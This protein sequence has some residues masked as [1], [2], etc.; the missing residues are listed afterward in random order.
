MR[1]ISS[2]GAGGP[3]GDPAGKDFPDNPE[4]FAA[5]CRAAAMLADGL[6]DWRPAIVHAHDWQAALTPV[7]LRGS[8]VGSVLTIHNI[9]FMGL[10]PIAKATALGPDRRRG[11][12]RVLGQRFHAQGRA[13]WR[14]SA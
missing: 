4:R 3:Y 10:A 8:G 11:R 6:D 7:H 9:A 13:W 5:L 12:L 14:P 2:T 1:P